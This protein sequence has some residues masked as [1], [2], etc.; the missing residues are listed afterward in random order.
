MGYTGELMIVHR[1]LE[2]PAFATSQ[3]NVGD[4]IAQILV[5]RRE[6]VVWCEVETKEQL[7]VT[8]RGDGC[9]GSSGR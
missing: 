8:E 4:R 6:R 9:F 1:N 2:N 5:R 7:G 3:Y